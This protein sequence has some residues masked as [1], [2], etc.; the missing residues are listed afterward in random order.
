[1][2]HLAF[3]QCANA[4][5]RPDFSPEWAQMMSGVSE[6]VPLARQFP[7]IVQVAQ[8]QPISVTKVLNP[9]MAKF[10]E[11][12]L[13]SASSMLCVIEKR[14]QHLSSSLIDSELCSANQSINLIFTAL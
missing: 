3:A 10:L 4:L 14:H 1:M 9:L 12:K 5:D 6:I 11:Y 13:V 7:G 2:L 8:A